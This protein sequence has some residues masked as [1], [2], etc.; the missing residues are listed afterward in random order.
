MA[1]SVNLG[2]AD[3]V[4]GYDPIP[5]LL[6]LVLP[7]PVNNPEDDRDTTTATFL[8]TGNLQDLE[9]VLTYTDLTDS[10]G[11]SFILTEPGDH[12]VCAVGN[13]LIDASK[14]V[15]HCE[16]IMLVSGETIPLLVSH[17]P[18]GDFLSFTWGRE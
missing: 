6:V 4:E 5:G 11:S 16:Q 8:L 17:S 9:D 3:E 12:I 2:P 1:V 14:R 13:S 10:E 7:P 18:R 15:S